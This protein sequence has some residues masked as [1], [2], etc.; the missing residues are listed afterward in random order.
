MENMV[1]AILRYRM[2]LGSAEQVMR[3]A[4]LELVPAMRAVSGFIAY[5]AVLIGPQSVVFVTTYRDRLGADVANCAADE[6]VARRFA[7]VMEGP[8]KVTIGQVRLFL[9]P[10]VESAA[11]TTAA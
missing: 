11:A 1:T 5:Q 7:S 6:W 4:E 3:L 10:G 9:N 8:P 2:K